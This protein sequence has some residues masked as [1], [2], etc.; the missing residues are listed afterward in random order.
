MKGRSINEIARDLY[1]SKSTVSYWCRDIQLSSAQLRRL[2]ERREAGGRI[3]RLISSEKKRAQRILDTR[4]AEDRGRREVG[5]ITKRDFFMLG[6]G[7]YWGEGYKKGNEECGFTNSNPDI[8]R[9][10]IRWVFETYGISKK[11]LILRVSINEAHK[12]RIG[13]VERYWA[14]VTG[15]SS[16][17]F[18]Q[19]SL[20]KVQ[21]RKVYTNTT[22]HFGTLRVKVRRATA[23]RRQ[24]L[25]SISAVAGYAS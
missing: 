2:A 9:A 19:A 15:I 25:G 18:T 20:I 7:L 8:I 22:T 11:H 12:S 17:Q 5:N 13:V 21:S 6:L 23:L 3:G 10:F 4:L 24:I 14:R 1:T 16:S